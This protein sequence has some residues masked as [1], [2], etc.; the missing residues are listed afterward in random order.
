MTKLLSTLI[1]LLVTCVVAVGQEDEFIFRKISPQEGFTYANIKTIAEDANGFIWFGTEHGL[2]RYNGREGQ[3]FIHQNG[4]PNTILGENIEKIHKDKQG[5]LWVVTIDGV[6][7]FDEGKQHFKLPVLHEVEDN[8]AKYSYNDLTENSL[9]ELFLLRSNKICRISLVDSS[10]KAMNIQ[11]NDEKDF[12]TCF[13][14][15]NRDNLWI[16]TD[17]GNVYTSPGPYNNFHFVCHFRT[18]RI[19]SICM[20]NSTFW[21][22]YNANGTDHVNQNGLLIDYYNENGDELTRIPSNRV[23]TIVKDSYNRIW[24]GTYN[25][26][27]MVS[28]NKIQII[29][30]DYYNNLPHNSIHSLFVDSKQGI[31]IGTWTGGVAF[32]DKND[33]QFLHFNRNQGNKS[34]NSNIVSSFA[35]DK[36]GTIWVSTEDGGLNKFNRIKKEFVP[37]NANN[38]KIGSM[39]IK[40]LSTGNDDVLWVGTFANGLWFFNLKNEKFYRSPIFK[41]EDINIY[42]IQHD[43]SGLWLG[44]YGSGLYYY[45]LPSGELKNFKTNSTDPTAISSNLVRVLL[46]DS[47]GGLWVGTQNGLN[48]K[49]KGSDKFKRYFYNTSIQSISNNQIFHLFEDSAGQIWIG[50]GGGGVNCYNSATGVFSVL[51]PENGLAGSSVFGILEDKNE[52]MWF[53]TEN[54]ISRYSPKTKTF[55]NYNRDDGLQGN[56]FNPAAVFECSNGEFLFGGP[57]GFNLFNPQ[58]LAENPVPPKVLITNLE[59]NN[60]K[61]NPVQNDGPI[62]DAVQILNELKLKHYQNSLSFEFVANN[63]IQPRKNQFRYRLVNYQD[64]WIEAGNLGKATFTKIPPGKY[65]FEVSGSN[66]DGVWSTEPT[67]LKINILYPFWRSNFAYLLYFLFLLV[68]A[69]VIRRE[70]ILRQ[71]LKN[72]LLVEKVQRENE[73]NLHQM[74]LQIFT[75]ISHE[76]RTPLTLILSPLELILKKK[77]FDNDTKDHLTMIQRNAQRLSM[78]INQIIDFRKFELNKIGYKSEKSDVVKICTAIS[79]HFDVYAKDKHILF[80]MDSKFS[81]FEMELDAEKLDKILFNLLSN[82]FKFTPE[83]GIIRLKIKRLNVQKGTEKLYS[84]NPEI[85]G[86][87]LAISISNSGVAIPDDEMPRIFDRFYKTDPEKNQGTGIGLHLCREY[88]KLLG[89]AI[90]VQNLPAEGVVF[91]VLLP[92]KAETGVSLAKQKTTKILSGTTN[93]KSE[94]I[95]IFK[96]DKKELSHSILVVEDNIDM[97]KQIRNLLMNDYKIIVAS[98]GNQGLEMALEILP[99]LIVSDVI[100]PGMDGLELCRKIK[101]DI[102]T[103]HI[104]VIL[105]TALSETD[106]QIDGLETG[107]DAYITKPFENKLLKAQISNLLQLRTKLKKSFKESEEK[108]ADDANLTQRD[109][110]LVERSIQIIEHHLLDTNFSVEQLADELG[111]SR[112]SLHRKMRVLTSQSATEFIRY[113]RMKKALKLMKE[114]DLNIDEI[115]FAVGFNSHSYFTQCFKKLYG[116]TPSE[117]Q[118]ELKMNKKEKQP[119]IRYKLN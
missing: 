72:Q 41:S 109:K 112:S 83:G 48:Y 15:D 99:D 80:E 65:L 8:I 86:N 118:S 50:T 73:E 88:S 102:H 63:Y 52:N 5:N 26:I 68:S 78:L 24:I 35:E 87:V 96:T 51:L 103:S 59:I 42:A 113:V 114:S 117:Y 81:K 3:K 119:V 13:T 30:K 36:T 89:G 98:N 53:S 21:L 33:N 93:K 70:I 44:T 29:K 28:R 55:K 116:K 54:G 23:R 92:L 108:W 79:N 94:S 49:P 56:Q 40:C 76:F 16:G 110:N 106:K 69:W 34:L 32:L 27:A 37:F 77:Y 39:N 19:Q 14:F 62:Q 90:T 74:K 31:W 84:T 46:L 71:K 97:Q 6:C 85:N 9:G 101:G 82:A 115:G 7:I 75:N 60:E 1:L 17:Q 22:G 67:Q 64:E 2:Y 25:G 11:L 104:P 12:P 45:D 100:M 105:L 20:D 58:N 38:P 4:N 43:E 111:V 66:N 18:D 10:L 95:D 91:S 57:N 61:V 47:Y 107:A